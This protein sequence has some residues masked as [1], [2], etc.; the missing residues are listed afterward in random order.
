MKASF[1]TGA[2]ALAFLVLGFE[3]AL[4]VH[5]AA[6]ERVVANRD[7]PDTVFVVQGA[8]EDVPSPTVS[9][10][11]PAGPPTLDPTADAV[12]PLSRGW[13][14]S[15]E[16]TSSR[17]THNQKQNNRSGLTRLAEEGQTE[18]GEPVVVERMGSHG[19]A[20]RAMYEK[21]PQR[22][23]ESFRFNPNTVKF[24]ELVRLG[25]TE[26]QAQS[27]INYREKGGRFRRKADFAKSYVVADSV[28]KRLAPFID[29]PKIDINKADSASFDSLPGIGGW[30]AH[31]MV[32]YR[33]QL[34]GYSCPEQLMEIWHFDQEKYDGLKDLITCSP[35]EPYPFWSGSV[36]DIRN[37]PH[38]RNWQTARDIAFYRDHNPPENHTVDGLLQAGILSEEQTARL[39]RCRLK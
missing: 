4:F 12:P 22:R 34:R 9:P 38:I 28:F 2:I 26:K 29:I 33:E 20:A 37:H 11:T 24:E 17:F 10:G 23:V 16:G 35:S 6:V 39:R 15:R 30:F 31:R 8:R 19:A 3:L 32:E 14:R 1:K 18:G 25:F 27:I 36:E 5:R 7:R 13:R 21:A